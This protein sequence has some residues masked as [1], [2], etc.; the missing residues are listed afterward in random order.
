[1]VAPSQRLGVGYGLRLGVRYGLRPGVYYRPGA[2]VGTWRRTAL[3]MS[4]D[5]AQRLAHGAGRANHGDD[6]PALRQPREIERGGG[7]AVL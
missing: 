6:I 1:M 2:A 3:V 5:D 7:A 4:A